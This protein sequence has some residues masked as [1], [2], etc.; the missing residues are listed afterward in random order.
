MYV[1]KKTKWQNRGGEGEYIREIR[2]KEGDDR[3]SE[4]D[5]EGGERGNEGKNEREIRIVI[6]I[7]EDNDEG[8]M[9]LCRSIKV[10]DAWWLLL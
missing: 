7:D 2:E 10:L 9:S 5:Q 6:T 8:G 4:R 1:K 3:K